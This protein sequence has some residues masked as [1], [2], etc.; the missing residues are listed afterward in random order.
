MH[1]ALWISEV[2][3]CIIGHL[4][5]DTLRHP[6]GRLGED[7]DK[8]GRPS[9]TGN[10]RKNLSC[11]LRTCARRRL[12]VFEPY[13]DTTV[14]ATL[15]CYTSFKETPPFN[16]KEWNVVLL[17]YSLRVQELTLEHDE[18]S[19]K[20]LHSLWFHTTLL[21]PNLCSLL[22]LYRDY[23]A[24]ASIRLLLSPSLAYLD[25]WVDDGD[26]TSVLAFLESYHILCPN[27]KSLCLNH[28]HRFPRVTDAI[29]RA[30][31]RSP[32]LNVGDPELRSP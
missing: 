30:I 1:N 25:T 16:G 3:G 27:L 6:A 18:L 13:D 8:A 28:S 15:V 14:D 2:L 7:T 23:T 4:A 12:A 22:W 10:A 5:K 9:G 31:T 11:F 24:F 21:L 20:I 19:L 17:R 26:H 29:S 32:K